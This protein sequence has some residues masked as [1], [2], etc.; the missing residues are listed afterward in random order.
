MRVKSNWFKG[1]EKSPQEIGGAVA[2]NI[3]RIGENA[4]RNMR[5]AGFDIAI[6]TQYFAFLTEFLVF[7]VQLAD[8]IAYRH[9]DPE[10]RTVFTTAVANRVAEN[11]AENQHLLMGGEIGAHK[12]AFIARLNLLADEYSNFEYEKGSENFSFIRCLGLSM[13]EVVD[14]RDK[15]WVTDQIMASEAPEA[16]ATLE[17]A[18]SGFLG[19]EPDRRPMRGN[20]SGE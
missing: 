4:L 1:G 3:W 16:V 6:G 20:T 10:A 11:L 19:L 9:Y 8:R 7:L 13:Q 17:R 14:E 5:K 2:F 12:A 18:M 15:T